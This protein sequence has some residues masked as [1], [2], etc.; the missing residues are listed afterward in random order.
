VRTPN[1]SPAPT[2]PPIALMAMKTA[3]SR[4]Q[5]AKPI[6]ISVW[7]QYPEDDA[8]KVYDT[9]EDCTLAP[10]LLT[11]VENGASEIAI[12]GFQRKPDGVSPMV[13]YCNPDP[14]KEVAYFPLT[15]GESIEWRSGQVIA[16][17]SHLYQQAQ[18]QHN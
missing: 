4:V 8:P 10:F 14:R 5:A 16:R 12:L 11:C 7:V 3:E 6:G 13:I 17:Y 2:I 15:D 1:P 18:A 9:R